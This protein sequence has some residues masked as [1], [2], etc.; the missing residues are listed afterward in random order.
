MENL[1][2][3]YREAISGVRG[4]STKPEKLQEFY[5]KTELENLK[6]FPK[7]LA[8]FC[9]IEIKNYI[10]FWV[11]L[12]AHMTLTAFYDISKDFIIPALI[13]CQP[14][15]RI[16]KCRKVRCSLSL[17]VMGFEPLTAGVRLVHRT[18]CTNNTFQW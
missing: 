9:K 14:I 2:L 7:F 13:L 10:V 4:L 15:C 12:E 11:Q 1:E 6:N 16:L 3:F 8:F 17:R 18:V 5:H